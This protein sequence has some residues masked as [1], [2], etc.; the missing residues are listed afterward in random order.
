MKT[1]RHALSGALLLFLSATVLADESYFLQPPGAQWGALGGT[2]FGVTSIAATPEGAVVAG[3]WTAPPGPD[4]DYWT[5]LARVA[6]DPGVVVL[7]ADFHD[8]AKHNRANDIIPVLSGG[9]ALEG[10]VFTGAK[11]RYDVDP[12]DPRIEWGGA[13]AWLVKTDTQF[14]KQWEALEGPYDEWLEGSALISQGA[15]Y[16]VGGYRHYLGYGSYAGLLGTFDSGGTLVSDLERHSILERVRDLVTTHDGGYGLATHRGIAKL[17]SG[18]A[19]DWIVGDA[20]PDPGFL[21]DRYSTLQETPGGD[22]VAVGYR[23]VQTNDVRG[24]VLSRLTTGGDVV[25]SRYHAGR[26]GRDFVL[27]ADEG[28][29]V[30]DTRR[31]GFNGG[32]DLRLTRYTSDGHYDYEVCLGEAGDETG[33][34]I[35]LAEDG[36]CLVAGSADVDGTERLWV[37]KTGTNQSPPLVSFSFDPPSPVFRGQ[38]VTFDASSSSAPGSAIAAYLWDFGDGNTTNGPVVE[39]TYHELGSNTVTL[40]VVTTNSVS[41]PATAVVEV[42]GLEIQ[43]ERFFGTDDQDAVASLVEARDGGFILTGAATVS[44]HD[45]WLFKTDRRGHVVWEKFIN[46]GFGG[47]Q[48]GRHVI[49]AHDSGYVVAGYD[50]HYTTYW[51]EDAWLLKVDE[52]GELAWPIR[53]FGE[54]QSHEK[55]WCVAATDDGGYILCGSAP[56][57]SIDSAWLVKTDDEGNLEWARHCESGNSRQAHWVSPAADGGY[58]LIADANAYPEWFLKTDA[59][60]TP[61]WTNVPNLYDSWNWIGTRAPPHSGYVAVGEV[62]RTGNIAMRFLNP[63]GQVVSTRTW[64]GTESPQE[65]D[66]GQ[67]AART[68]DDGYLITGYVSLRAGGPWSLLRRELAL[69][70]TDADGNTH[71]MEFHPGTTNQNEKGIAAVALADGS[72][73]VLGVREY[74]DSR[75]WLFKLAANHPP[76]PDLQLATPFAFQ[77]ARMTF[78]AGLSTD[79]DGTVVAY[80]WDFGDGTTTNGMVAQHAYTQPGQHEVKLTVIDDQDAER[81]LI[82]SV[83]ILGVWVDNSQNFTLGDTSQTNSPLSEPDTYPTD[84]V[85]LLLEW[86]DAWGF[87]LTGTSTSSRARDIMVTFAETLPDD[88]TLFQLPSWTPIAYD[89]VDAHTLQVSLWVPS[90]AVDLTFVLANALPSPGILAAGPFA[91]PRLSLTFDT[92]PEILYRVERTLGLLP[93]AWTNVPHART[94]GDPAT[95]ESLDGTGSAETLYMDLP[96][97]DAALFRL[98]LESGSP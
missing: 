78:D 73:V 28:M 86:D 93:L 38:V 67:H 88:F 52:D 49:R 47:T 62:G 25:W 71:W 2:N 36:N 64:T 13:K 11:H 80:E 17:T 39:H 72:Y 70:K 55:V 41:R 6:G 79:S 19:L 1:I 26:G 65:N 91:G 21:P 32:T 84:G 42:L 76:D 3:V 83:F 12:Y 57:N 61:V 68:P 14:V 90:G 43:W 5:V 15:D 20:S 16:F 48:Q 40:T 10:F 58:A 81:S 24:L 96:G 63:D 27:T 7:T 75:S 85:P 50:Y 23:L 46:D 53:A 29:L 44:N 31:D 22:L 77:G 82:Q 35:D 89:L 74:G 66:V 87:H 54:P 60:G 56:T 94:V 97:S 18:L 37:V 92:I 98:K 59:L 4:I 95:F 9:G 33:H 8:E 51:Y 69:V 45:L 34:V 30:V